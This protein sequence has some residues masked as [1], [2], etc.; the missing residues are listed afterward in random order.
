MHAEYEWGFKRWDPGLESFLGYARLSVWFSEL[1]KK[2]L[3][4]LVLFCQRVCLISE[5]CTHRDPRRERDQFRGKEGLRRGRKRNWDSEVEEVRERFKEWERESQKDGAALRCDDYHGIWFTILNLLKASYQNKYDCSNSMRR[6]M[7]KAV[8]LA[9]LPEF[10]ILFLYCSHPK[11]CILCY[12]DK[13]PWPKTSKGR[14][15]LGL[16]LDLWGR[17]LCDMEA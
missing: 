1:G 2:N 10:F 4:D 8:V 13:T 9:G 7:F 14:V 15:Y 5:K 3:F 12:C 6:Y 11:F 17:A 16:T